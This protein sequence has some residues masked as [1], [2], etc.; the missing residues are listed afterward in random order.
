MAKASSENCQGWRPRGT[1]SPAR[2]KPKA[3]AHRASR[4]GDALRTIP[5]SVFVFA[6][7][8]EAIM[9]HQ[10]LILEADRPV[11]TRRRCEVRL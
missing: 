5:R 8:P 2:E 7:V 9:L 4:A 1:S 3:E 6:Q 10:P 11:T